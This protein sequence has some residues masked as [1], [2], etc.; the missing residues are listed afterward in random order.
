[1]ATAEVE[2]NQGRGP[3]RRRLTCVFCGRRLRGR[4]DRNACSKCPRPAVIATESA[5]IRAAGGG[6][7]VDELRFLEFL[8]C[9]KKIPK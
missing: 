1:M 6:V 8:E 9:Q 2:C 7:L 5:A 4:G 3:R